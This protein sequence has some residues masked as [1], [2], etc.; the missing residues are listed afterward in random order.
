MRRLRLTDQI[1]V[2]TNETRTEGLGMR[3][4]IKPNT[5]RI[6]P[7]NV[8]SKSKDFSSE[9]SDCLVW[10]FSPSL[11]GKEEG[12]VLLTTLSFAAE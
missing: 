1:E 10:S 3:G 4:A 12:I 9:F 8:K 6:T 2:S 11:R 7:E 5:Q